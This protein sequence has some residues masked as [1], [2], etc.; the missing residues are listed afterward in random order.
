MVTAAS[1]LAAF[2]ANADTVE[3]SAKGPDLVDSTVGTVI[4]IVKV[5]ACSFQ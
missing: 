3:V 2:P 1:L 5:G 4:D